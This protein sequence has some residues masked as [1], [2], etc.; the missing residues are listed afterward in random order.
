[1]LHWWGNRK[2][3]QLPQRLLFFADSRD[4]SEYCDCFLVR[5]PSELIYTGSD[6]CVCHND[7]NLFSL[8]SEIQNFFVSK[9]VCTVL[10]SHQKAN[11]PHFCH[12]SFQ[13]PVSLSCPHGNH[14]HSGSF[15]RSA[16]RS[17]CH[18]K[19]SN[20][21]QS[22]LVSDFGY[23][24]RIFCSRYFLCNFW[25]TFDREL[26]TNSIFKCRDSFCLFWKCICNEIKVWEEE[27]KSF[28]FEKVNPRSFYEQGS[29]LNN[30]AICDKKAVD[31][32]QCCIIKE[33][34]RNWHDQSGNLRIK[35]W[36]NQGRPKEWQFK[37]WWIHKAWM[38]KRGNDG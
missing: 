36:L 1:M 30:Y 32:G 2:S 9:Q 10:C 22:C 34:G 14:L 15:F 4:Y 8:Y 35:W 31:W 18:E 33:I 11:F 3:D 29:K 23:L 12:Y 16:I 21:I 19:P 5:R 38:E 37:A 26:H 6:Y 7:C 20:W 28:R 27:D 24:W 17:L 13:L 25:A